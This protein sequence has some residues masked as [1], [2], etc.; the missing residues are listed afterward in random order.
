MNV[1]EN[2]L[3]F[4]EKS[5]LSYRKVKKYFHSVVQSGK[6]KCSLLLVPHS[7]E[8]IVKIDL[9]IN[10]LVFFAFLASLLLGFSVFFSIKHFFFH[11]DTKYLQ[12]SGNK[13]KNHFL[14]HK[15]S[16]KKL[17]QKIDEVTELTN[18]LYKTIWGKYFTKQ[19]LFFEAS[20]LDANSIFD[21]SE[22]SKTNMKIFQETVT[23]YSRFNNELTFLQPNFSG[24]IEYLETREAI[25]QSM[26]Q[27][28]PLSPSVGFTSSLFGRRDDPFA[29]GDGEF[30]SGIDFAAPQN[31]PI[32]ATGPGIIASLGDSEG[33]LGKSIRINHG[34]GIYSVFG[35]CSQFKV[36]EGQYVQR[37]ELIGLVGSTGKATGS[38]VH[39][40]VHIGYDPPMDPK[41]FINFE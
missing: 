23:L 29:L 30:H 36:T 6:T 22:H 41:E 35:H 39:Y 10:L 28:R 5:I 1:S 13:N 40:E 15:H 25:Y 20:L 33:G 4:Y 12:I 38:H 31:T 18:E 3:T 26:P 16:T 24:T 14:Y 27:G 17:R 9:S 34:Y 11:Q 19:Y 7:Q 32:Y 8:A 37:G 21:S 2:H